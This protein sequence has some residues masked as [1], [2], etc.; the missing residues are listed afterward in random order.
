MEY[1]IVSKL[2]PSHIISTFCCSLLEICSLQYCT[3]ET[4][5]CYLLRPEH[6]GEKQAM[7][8]IISSELSAVH[9]INQAHVTSFLTTSVL[10]P[11]AG[12]T[13]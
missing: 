7:V 5:R 8:V 6:R 3:A 1:G 11:D 13:S 12:T 4:S 2:S 9:S 10:L